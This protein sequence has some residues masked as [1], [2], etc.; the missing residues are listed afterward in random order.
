[1][2]LR[3][4]NLDIDT[5]LAARSGMSNTG[6][7]KWSLTHSKNT[8]VFEAL[9]NSELTFQIQNSHVLFK[10]DHFKRKHVCQASFFR[11]Y[12]SFRRS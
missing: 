8:T 3:V 5:S 2:I 1:M 12:V 10:R 9:E 6:Y 11:G 4:N 7:V